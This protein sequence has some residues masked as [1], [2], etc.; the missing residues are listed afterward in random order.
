[1]FDIESL[2]NLDRKDFY[3][4]ILLFAKGLMDGEKDTIANLA[5]ISSLL[6]QTMENINWAGFY[7]LREDELVLGPFQGNPACIRIQIGSGVCG[8]A[9]SQNVTQLVKDVHQYPGHIACDGATNSEIVIPIHNKGQIVG[10][11][12]IDSP[13]L[14]RFKDVD[15]ENLEKLVELIEGACNWDKY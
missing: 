11:L 4:S 13:M 6:Y 7:L 10:V 9:V 5:N 1:M 15:R 2:K 14:G 3:E 12:D 8:N